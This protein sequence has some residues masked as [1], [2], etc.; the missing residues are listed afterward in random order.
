MFAVRRGDVIY[1]A[2]YDFH[3][4]RF[5]AIRS[6]IEKGIY[7]S[8]ELGSLCSAIITGFAAGRDAQAHDDEEGIPHIRPLNVTSSGEFTLE[9]TKRVPLTSVSAS[10]L[11]SQGEVLFNNTNSMAWVGKSTVFD[12]LTPC[13]CSNHITRLV[14]KPEVANPYYLAELLNALR[15]MRLFE[16][17][18]THFNNQS[19]I[20]TYTLSSLRVPVPDIQQQRELVAV[21]QAA[22]ERR[23]Q[24][25]READE[26]FAS[27]DAFLLDTLGLNTN[28]AENKSTCAIRAKQLQGAINPERYLGLHLEKLILQ[29]GHTSIGDIG[30]IQEF[31]MNPSTTFADNLCDLIRIDDLPNNPLGVEHIRTEAGADMQGSFFFVEHEDILLAR[32]GPTLLNRKIVLC[33]KPQRQTFASPEFLVIRC[34]P[35]WNPLFVNWML[36]TSLYTRIMYSKARGSTPS[37]YRLIRED[38]V[39]TLFPLVSREKQDTLAH[40]IQ[41]RL[42]KVSSLRAEAEQGWERAK[43]EF[44]RRL[45]GASD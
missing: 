12:D 18:A 38:F 32:L 21:M 35:N 36:R 16:L 1:R 42:N 17:L 31:K 27:I 15:G 40:E 45:L 30:N 8:A 19:G 11:L 41:L 26:Q 4:P 28:F 2:D 10:D 39:D 43:A 25:L 24:L 13:V 14:L 6:I 22:R 5:R 34:F 33:P 23:A 9:G 44:E 37:R 7:P 20:N 3:T 29:I